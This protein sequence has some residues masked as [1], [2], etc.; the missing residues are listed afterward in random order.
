MLR[1]L[2][3]KQPAFLKTVVSSRKVVST[4]ILTLIHGMKVTIESKYNIGAIILEIYILKSV[5][6]AGV[7]FKMWISY[8]FIKKVGGFS[9]LINLWS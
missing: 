2:T 5:Q 1:Y 8:E 3:L 4:A 9:R 7:G 6:Q